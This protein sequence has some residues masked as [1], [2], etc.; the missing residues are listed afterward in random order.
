[1][2]APTAVLPTPKLRANTGSTGTST[3]N[4]TA[5][6]NAITPR[7][8]TSRG[9]VVRDAQPAPRPRRGR[10]RPSVPF[11]PPNRAPNHPLPL[12]RRSG[13]EG[14][15]GGAGEEDRRIDPLPMAPRSVAD[16]HGSADRPR[17][18]SIPSVRA[19]APRPTSPRPTRAAFDRNVPRGLQI[20]ASWAWRILLVAALVSGR[21]LDPP[22]PVR[23]RHPAGRRHPA[24][25]DAVPGGQAAAPRGDCRER[26][27]PPSRC[28]AASS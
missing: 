26:R 15:S 10:H 12:R 3:P 21:R 19:A 27:P 8:R 20:A 11:A 23:G 4:P 18:C 2:T 16:A 25:G 13:V 7:T 28:S 1:M 6:Q 17:R 5:T 9:R 14:G 22:L 24:G